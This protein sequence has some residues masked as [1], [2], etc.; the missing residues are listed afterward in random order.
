VLRVKIRLQ[1]LAG[2]NLPYS[3][4]LMMSVTYSRVED[5][6]GWQKFPSFI[7]ELIT[8]HSLKRICEIGAGANPTLVPEFVQSHGLQYNAVD[9]CEV[10]IVKSGMAQMVA[11]DICTA[12]T[13]I[14]G[15]PYDLVFS[16]MTA[17][18]FW[19][20]ANAYE[21]MFRSLA[22]GGMCVHSFATLYSLP[23]LLNRFLPD[24]V[25]SFLLNCFAPRDLDKHDKF[26]AY[27]SHC[28]GPIKSQLQF[29]ERIGYEIVEYRG[30]FGHTYYRK[31]MPFVHF[32]EKQKS[33]LLLKVPVAHLTSYA[34]IILQRS[35][36]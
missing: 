12:N 29:F 24:S 27:Y 5:F 35:C 8:T 16:R 23:F 33:G 36:G 28:R 22:P 2:N 3:G 1:L 19:D 25:S 10:E 14:P 34:T 26:K 7:E 30:Y 4:D 18:H 21:N 20:S 32:I 31:R 6:D 11:F 13:E 9:E 17:E 15:A